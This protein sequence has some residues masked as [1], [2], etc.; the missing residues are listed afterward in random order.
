MKDLPEKPIPPEP[1]ECCGGGS[2][3]PCV[4]DKYYEDLHQWNEKWKALT[5]ESSSEK[6]PSDKQ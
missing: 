2:C 1:W 3:C 4:W 5:I 6:Q